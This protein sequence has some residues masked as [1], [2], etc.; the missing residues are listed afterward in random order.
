MDKMFAN[1]DTRAFGRNS[2]SVF[3]ELDQI[4]K[5]QISLAVEHISLENLPDEEM[6]FAKETDE[7]SEENFKKN[8]E[9]FAKK[10]HDLN[11]LMTNLNNLIGKVSYNFI[12]LI[13]GN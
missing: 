12:I 1:E 11:N 5:K 4:R 2:D 6:P 7:D 8:S 13:C 3:K 10:E 9:Q